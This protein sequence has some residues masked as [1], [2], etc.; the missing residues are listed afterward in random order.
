MVQCKFNKGLSVNE[1]DGKTV[2]TAPTGAV[3]LSEFMDTL[4]AGILNKKETGCGATTVVLENEENVIIACPTR[5]LIINKVSQYPNER[6]SYKLL[7][8]QKGV[9]QQH[10]EAY[11]DEC[12]GKQPIKIMVTYD[13]FPRV[14]S[15]TKQKRIECKIVVD[16]YQELLDAY[17]Y[18][19][20]A[21][22]NLLNELKDV[23]NVTYLSATPIPYK[24]RPKELLQLPE[25]EIDWGDNVRI[26]PFR[27]KCN[28]P[29]S[30]AANIIK[31][32]KM[33]HPFELNGHVVKEYFFFVNSVS[34]IRSIVKSTGLTSDDVKIICANN[35]INKLKLRD[36]PIG[37]AKG[38][39]KTFTF[40]TKTAFY[41]ADFYSDAGLAIIVSDGHA[42]SSLLD[43]ATDITQIAGRIRTKENLFRNIILHIY[44]TD[45]MCESKVE[46]EEM[47]HNRLLEAQK[48]VKAFEELSADLREVI[49]GRIRVD[50]PAEF[51]FYNADK[52]TVE[53][54]EMKI[55]HA[56]YKFETIDN[57]YS[58]GL[59][60]R[61]A[62]LNAGYN[63]KDADEMIE[64]IRQ[65]VYFGMGGSN[66]E[67]LYKMYSNDRKQNPVIK[68][69]LA[70]DVSM[71]N[72]I[73]PLAYNLLGDEEVE[74]LGYDERK[75]R[76]MVH[77][78]LPE[79]QDALKKELKITFIIGRRY[80]FKEIKY[81][82]G[83]CF[84]KLRIGIAAKATLI[85]EYFD[86]KRV[87]IQMEHKRIDGF[88][89]NNA[90]FLCLSKKKCVDFFKFPL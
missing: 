6:C 38:K 37:E 88:Q 1:I 36:L 26:R 72:N 47:L 63:M 5:Y 77:F 74:R 24:W 59:S 90:L 44:N 79:T 31:N 45:V 70:K 62:Y 75:V 69:E 33:G 17:V 7:G 83:L 60:I 9:G 48:T 82:L 49:V 14:F 40:C 54:D 65:N 23:P 53:V 84:Q 43:I 58:N 8:V 46:Y 3:Y 25:Y 81:Q 64:N 13:S 41:G 12:S 4:P 51:V 80:S 32:H 34:A 30:L 22:R 29:F 50:D 42:K 71:Q 21:I 78:K 28:H 76:D 16:E 55:A 56:E 73:V 35:E 18:R 39:N 61:D 66:F 68:S 89:I 52:Q 27:M 15:L 11:V 86:T 10:I 57:V 2:I 67:V 85:R 20:T 87:K 19:N